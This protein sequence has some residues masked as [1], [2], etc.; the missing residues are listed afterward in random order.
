MKGNP[1][2]GIVLLL[3][4]TL[5][6]ILGV[7]DKGKRIMQILLGTDKAPKPADDTAPKEPEKKAGSPGEP[8]WNLP[9]S[10]AGYNGAA[11]ANGNPI[12]EA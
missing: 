8:G 9:G 5:L 11:P 6:I 3:V 7:T 1:T 4:A 2:G 10:F 12:Q